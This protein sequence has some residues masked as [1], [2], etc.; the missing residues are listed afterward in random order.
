[1]GRQGSLSTQ[2]AFGMS[3]LGRGGRVSHERRVPR[4]TSSAEPD[5]WPK[6]ISSAFRRSYG[7]TKATLAYFAFCNSTT[8]NS[9]HVTEIRNQP[10]SF[11]LHRVS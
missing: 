5:P 8:M 7:R 2:H 3:V 6:F 10:V 4:R 1:V 11:N 9:Y